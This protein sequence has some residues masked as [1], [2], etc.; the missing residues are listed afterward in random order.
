MFSKKAIRGFVSYAPWFNRYR[1]NIAFM[2]H[3]NRM[4]TMV[5]KRT[6]L[7]WSTRNKWPSS[8]C[9]LMVVLLPFP[10]N[11]RKVIPVCFRLSDP[12]LLSLSI[13]KF[14]CLGQC[15]VCFSLLSFVSAWTIN[16]HKCH[17]ICLG[18]QTITMPICWH[19]IMHASIGK[20][21]FYRILTNAMLYPRYTCRT[22]GK[23]AGDTAINGLQI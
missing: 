6:E 12:D 21:W 3:R 4:P 23:Y 11:A 5:K 10:T 19:I 20:A 2:T 9:R 7:Y 14:S 17:R 1:V 13:F 22:F 16:L 18:I 8:S 15:D